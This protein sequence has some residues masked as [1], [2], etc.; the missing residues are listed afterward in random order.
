MSLSN[1]IKFGVIPSSL[2]AAAGAPRGESVYTTPGTYSWVAPEGVTSVSVVAIGGGQGGLWDNSGLAEFRASGGDGGGLGWKNN[3]TVI[4]GQAYTVVVGS[5]GFR[6]E[7]SGDPSNAGLGSSSYFIDLTTVAGLASTTS[8]FNYSTEGGG[9]VGDGGGFG[10]GGRASSGGGGG[11]GAGGYTGNGGL[12]GSP[13]TTPGQ[14]DAGTGGAGAG[15][16]GGTRI[17]SSSYTPAGQGGGTGIYGEGNS[18]LSNGQS[19]SGGNTTNPLSNP[20]TA[21]YGGGGGG[22]FN[23]SNG[24]TNGAGGAVRIVWGEG[25][26]FP[27][28]DVGPTEV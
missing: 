12:G 2:A 23:A 28:T 4:P 9:Y 22:S 27:S 1:F 7:A 10:G 15:G 24:A 3:I 19:G 14:G 8:H 6:D 26:A 11:G 13:G 17:T 21:L 5:G 16:I 18:G 20:Y 25:R